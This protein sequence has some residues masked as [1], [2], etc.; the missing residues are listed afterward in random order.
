MIDQ[1]QKMVSGIEELNKNYLISDERYKSL[2]KETKHN[3]K[4]IEEVTQTYE[5]K[6]KNNTDVLVAI[7]SAIGVIGAAA[8]GFAQVFF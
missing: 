5:K 6:M 3:T 1:Q 8:F 2:E 4:K 7:I